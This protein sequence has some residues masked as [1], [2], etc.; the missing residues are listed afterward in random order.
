[1]IEDA[2]RTEL[3]NLSGLSVYPLLL[4]DPVQEGITFQR[5]SDPEMD[6]GMVR[7]GLIAGRFQISIYRINDY[8]ALVGLDRAIWSVWRDI[9]H[10][11]ISDYP[12]Q[13]VERAS[14]IQDCVTLTS[15]RVQYRL[16]RDYIIYFYEDSS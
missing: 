3:S 8:T 12:V 1:M 2:I 4:P 16:V 9:Q 5:I 7:T 10:G 15:N 11:K 6:A 14:I 13:Y